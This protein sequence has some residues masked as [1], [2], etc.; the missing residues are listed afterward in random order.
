MFNGRTHSSQQFC[1]DPTTSFVP[2]LS[3]FL[4]AKKE[5]LSS[6]GFT[7]KHRLEEGD[8]LSRRAIRNQHEGRNRYRSYIIVKTNYSPAGA[9]KP[10]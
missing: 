7:G 1:P 4:S 2:N 8:P 3:K 10:P 6:P 9:A 5:Y